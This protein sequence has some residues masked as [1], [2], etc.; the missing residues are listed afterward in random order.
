MLDVNSGENAYW[1]CM[2]KCVMYIRLQRMPVLRLWQ[3]SQF[4]GFDPG[5]VL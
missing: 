2:Y 5:N 1:K 3:Y 4:K